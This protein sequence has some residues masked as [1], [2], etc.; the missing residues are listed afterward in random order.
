VERNRV[1]ARLAGDLAGRGVAALAKESSSWDACMQMGRVACFLELFIVVLLLCM[2]AG[3]A[4][5]S[6]SFGILI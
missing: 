2:F 4:T 1:W 5:Y 6:C 3:I